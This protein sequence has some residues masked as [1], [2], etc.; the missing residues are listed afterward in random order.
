MV[1]MYEHEAVN[2]V[3]LNM[4]RDRVWIWV[5]GLSGIQAYVDL[6][7]HSADTQAAN[8]FHVSVWRTKK[9]NCSYVEL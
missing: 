3:N 5:S 8:I 9:P 1:L 7:D 2:L 4:E 6:K